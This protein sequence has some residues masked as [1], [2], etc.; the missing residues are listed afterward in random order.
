MTEA[1]EDFAEM[2]ILGLEEAM[3]HHKGRLSARVDWIEI[4]QTPP[5][6]RGTVRG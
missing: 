6:L 4:P 2:L 5:D 1:K 3:E